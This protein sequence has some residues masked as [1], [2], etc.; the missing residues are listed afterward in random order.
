MGPPIM[1]LGI[2]MQGLAKEAE[3]G[4]R[5]FVKPSSNGM[6]VAV[7]DGLGHGSEAAA[8]TRIAAAILAEYVDEPLITLVERCHQ[9]LK[10]T[11]GMAISLASFTPSTGTMAWLGVGNVEGALLYPGPGPGLVCKSL[12]LYAGIVGCNLP[13]L[14]A[15][16]VPVKRGDILVVVTDGIRNMFSKEITWD[17]NPQQIA[18]RILDRHCKGNDDALVLVARYC[19]TG[20]SL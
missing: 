13:R 2:A 6:L 15:K 18:D 16:T 7:M 5:Y 8:A 9:A 10:G 4:D 3:T 11:R 14:Y 17:G 20:G 12:L 19:G 1:E